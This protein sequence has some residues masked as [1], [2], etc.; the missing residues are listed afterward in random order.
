MMKRDTYLDLE[1]QYS[2]RKTEYDSI[3]LQLDK[4]EKELTDMHKKIVSL[5]EYL[6]AFYAGEWG[7]DRKIWW[8][9]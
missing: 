2:E 4:I 5:K 6:K 9:E 7:A 8:K 3:F 1:E